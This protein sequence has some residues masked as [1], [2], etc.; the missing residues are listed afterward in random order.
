MPFWHQSQ[1]HLIHLLTSKTLSMILHST[2]TF[3][4]FPFWRVSMQPLI[5]CYKY[6][7]KLNSYSNLQFTLLNYQLKNSLKNQY[8]VDLISIKLLLL[9]IKSKMLIQSFYFCFQWHICAKNR[10]FVCVNESGWDSLTSNSI[11]CRLQFHCNRICIFN[12]ILK[13]KE[14]FWFIWMNKP[15]AFSCKKDQ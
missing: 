2:N 11:C 13:W 7:L 4:S 8:V 15:T 3:V 1:H 12:P 10:V 14:N 5:F 6:L 9:S